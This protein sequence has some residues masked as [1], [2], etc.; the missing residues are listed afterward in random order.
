MEG[1]I[2]IFLFVSLFFVF[3]PVHGVD[4]SVYQ[5]HFRYDK[6][7]DRLVLDESEGVPVRVNPDMTL[8]PLEFFDEGTGGEFSFRFFF[9]NGEEIAHKNFDVGA[10]GPFLFA[11]P[12]VSFARSF[13]VYKSGVTSPIVSYNL[14]NFLTCN[15]NGV[16]EYEK[17][18]NF[19]TCLPDCVGTVVNFS[20]ETKK[21]L[22]QNNDVIRDPKSGEVLLR[23]IRAASVVSSGNATQTNDKANA[24]LL[25]L[26]AVAVLLISAGVFVI[27]RLRARNKKYGL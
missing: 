12:Y 25:I 19:E 27:L 3:F 6:S 7:A 9:E 15:R 8:N 2:R 14:S 4:A 10:S 11:V 13:A 16:C 1:R 23:G 20:D 21:L 24:F 22:K 17:G 5:V 26:G 18:E